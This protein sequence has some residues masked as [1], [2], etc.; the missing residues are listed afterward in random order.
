[1]HVV[2]MQVFLH[3]VTDVHI[4]P[5]IDVYVLTLEFTS[6]TRMLHLK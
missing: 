3:R 6:Y 4:T 2:K 5:H 1:M